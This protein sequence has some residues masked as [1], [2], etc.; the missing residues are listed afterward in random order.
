MSKVQFNQYATTGIDYRTFRALISGTPEP[1]ADHF[2]F[3]AL[4]AQFMHETGRGM[5]RIFKEFNNLFGMRPALQ[6]PKFY[7][8]T[9]DTGTG[10]YAVYSDVADSIAD[11]MHLDRYNEV[12][13]PEDVSM[14]TRYFEELIEKK[15]ATDPLYVRKAVDM[16]RSL[17]PNDELG[18]YEDYSQPTGEMND[19][20]NSDIYSESNWYDSLL[21]KAKTYLGRFATAAAVITGIFLAYK[22]YGYYRKRNK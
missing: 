8:D 1:V 19:D 22:L 16:Y 11:R 2:Y 5:S 18:A 10:R 15:Y 13:E 9:V 12:T 20:E 17:F 7:V 21:H 14:I 3:R 6:R 4:Y